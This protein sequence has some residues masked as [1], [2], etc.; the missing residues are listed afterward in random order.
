VD[1]DSTMKNII[2]DWEETV[3]DP[4]SAGGHEDFQTPCKSGKH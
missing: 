1:V 3:I 4:D 2:G